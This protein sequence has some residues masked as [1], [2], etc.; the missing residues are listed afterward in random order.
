M[1]RKLVQKI[2]SFFIQR[3]RILVVNGYLNSDEIAWST[4][5]YPKE[6]KVR[7][8][9][10][11]ETSEHRPGKNQNGMQSVVPFPVT[12]LVYFSNTTASLSRKRVRSE[13]L[14]SLHQQGSSS[15]NLIDFRHINRPYRTYFF[16]KI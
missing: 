12:R 2:Q 1:E 15:S 11:R 7:E 4:T 5:K 9:P 8:L 14:G 16:Y 6:S 3:K 10:C 13:H